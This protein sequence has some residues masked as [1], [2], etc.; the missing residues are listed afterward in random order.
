MDTIE[1]CHKYNAAY[2]GNQLNEKRT[3][4]LIPIF[5]SVT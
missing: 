1:K 2:L 4:S 3:V 5:G